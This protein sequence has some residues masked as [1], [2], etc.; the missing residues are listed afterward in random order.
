MTDVIVYG[1]SECMIIMLNLWHS[2]CFLLTVTTLHDSNIGK[3][4]E[5]DTIC[6]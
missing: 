3:C 1:K 2:N 6:F 4:T 5:Y